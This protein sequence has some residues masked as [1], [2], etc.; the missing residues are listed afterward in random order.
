MGSLNV[1][2]FGLC[3]PPL[4]LHWE[5]PIFRL[6]FLVQ[7]L[8]SLGQYSLRHVHWPLQC[9]TINIPL[10]NFKFFLGLE[11]DILQ[12]SAKSKFVLNICS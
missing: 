6:V 3:P 2:E 9:M 5:S 11:A 12:G 4:F 1:Y 10:F 8:N 7:Y